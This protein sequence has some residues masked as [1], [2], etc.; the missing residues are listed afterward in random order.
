MCS[1]VNAR[2]LNGPEARPAENQLVAWGRLGLLERDPRG[3][4]LAGLPRLA[5]IDD[6]S[7]P[8]EHRVRSYL[9]ANCAH[10][11]RPGGV[12]RRFDARY[13]ADPAS[14]LIG[15]DVANALGVHGARVFVA[16]D[17]SR[18]IAARRM[19]STDP[20]ARMPPLA[21]NVVDERAASA[22]REWIAGLGARPAVQ[23]VRPAGRP[24]VEAGEILLEAEVSGGR[25]ARRR[26]RAGRRPDRRGLGAAV[27]RG[28]GRGG[29]GQL[30]DHGPRPRRPGR[31][32]DVRP[33]DR[34]GRR[35]RPPR[36]GPGRPGDLPER[37]P[38]DVDGERLGPGRAGSEQRRAMPGMAGRSHRRPAS[39]TR[40][41]RP[42]RSRVVYRLAGEYTTFLADLGIDSEAGES[43]SV[44]FEVWADGRKLFQSG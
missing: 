15:G 21:S 24:V 28:L 4:G 5:A 35:P 2:Q 29:A 25:P 6:R 22:I 9:D 18:S 38:A 23:L 19:T 27:S 37:P 13:G 31:R 11:H 42:A 20:A 36:R 17:P 30:R 8:L 14:G 41:R 26:V 12:R 32:G 7:A 43:G 3:A 40:A 1:G 34:H 39:M 33:G 44:T 16:G 10:C